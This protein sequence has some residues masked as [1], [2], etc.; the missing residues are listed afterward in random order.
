MENG[1]Y[2]WLV[3][4]RRAHLSEG[5]GDAF[6]LDILFHKISVKAMLRYLRVLTSV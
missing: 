5:R 1:Q 3:L 2:G 6:F 4:S